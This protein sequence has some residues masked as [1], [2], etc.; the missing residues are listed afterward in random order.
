MEE[1]RLTNLI[2]SIS[3][4]EETRTFKNCFLKM[5]NNYLLTL[6]A[7]KIIIFCSKET[8]SCPFI[9]D[10][11]NVTI[12]K[13][14]G[15][16]Y[17]IFHSKKKVNF[18]E[19]KKFCLQRNLKIISITSKEQARFFFNKMIIKEFTENRKKSERSLKNF[20]KLKSEVF[21]PL[22]NF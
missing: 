2:F 4:P 13:F 3:C 8:I 10:S 7:S 22:S 5:N 19:M 15:K 9:N 11:K 21:I 12:E 17:Y 18:E 6:K 20:N 16:C 14:L 1:M